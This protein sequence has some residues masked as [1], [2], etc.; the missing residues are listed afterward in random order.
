MRRF[1]NEFLASV[2][3]VCFFS[4]FLISCK[5]DEKKKSDDLGATS[6][7]IN[8]KIKDALPEKIK[9]PGD[10]TPNPKDTVF[11]C[12]KYPLVFIHGFMGGKRIGGFKGVKEHFE[13][14]GCKVG[15]SEVSPVN[16]IEIRSQQFASQVKDY[17]SKNSIEKVNIIAHSQGGLDSRYAIAKLGL[18]NS[19]ASLTMLGTPHRGTLVADVMVGLAKSP[20]LGELADS[21]AQLIGRVVNTKG[22]KLDAD[23]VEALKSLTTKYA[24]NE[25]NPQV[26]DSPSV[27]YQSWAGRTGKGT[28]DMNKSML[29]G[30]SHM[31]LNM[32]G[33]N[34]GM[35]PVESAK[36]GEFRGVL[37]ADHLDLVGL[38]LEDAKGTKFKHLD[39]LEKVVTELAGK[40]F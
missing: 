18:E 5:D 26:P 20:K 4:T 37:D 1:T 23:L 11:S 33:P 3:M 10:V 40:G 24:N 14:K 36:W 34:D 13:S 22:G 27:Y 2:L 30:V 39:F 28:G 35:V 32:K 29:L 6:D 25:F 9:D 12:P 7:D 8:S 21:M 19:V 16:G 38:V 15:I 31:L 17:L